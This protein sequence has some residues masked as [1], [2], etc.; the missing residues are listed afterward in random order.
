MKTIFV[1]LPT[2]ILLLFNS[3]SGLPEGT[4]ALQGGGS[5]ST[6]GKEM[7]I[8]APNGSI[9]KHDR[10][11]LDSDETVRFNQ[12]STQARV[13]NRITDSSP[14]QIN[15][16][17]QA[18]GQVYLVN[19]AGV[20]FGEDSSVE[21][22]RLHVVAGQ[23]SDEDF[24]ARRD[25]FSNLSGLIANQGQ[26]QADSVSLSGGTVHN[27][28]QILAPDGYIALSAGTSVE[29]SELDGSL[30]VS[31]EKGYGNPSVR[32]SSVM[33]D[34]AGQA[35]FG[36]G[37]LKASQVNLSASAI[38]PDGQIKADHVVLAPYSYLNQS[39][40]ESSIHTPSLEIQ[41]T[42]T[43]LEVEL[44]SPQ[45]EI[46][47]L[48]AQGTFQKLGVSSRSTL[49]VETLP[50]SSQDLPS[51]IQARHLDLRS[52]EGD[53][54]IKDVI[55]PPQGATDSTLLV[56]A[57]GKVSLGK[58]SSDYSYLRR[59][60]YGQLLEETPEITYPDDPSPSTPIPS[61]SAFQILAANEV[62][63]YDLS[64]SL[65]PELVLALAKENPVFAALQSTSDLDLEGLSDTQLKVLLEYGYLS[66]YSYFLKINPPR[67]IPL[68][69]ADVFGGDF[70]AVAKS[71]STEEDSAEESEDSGES[72]TADRAGTVGRVASA[73]P[74]API[75]TPVLSPAA[76][77]LLDDALNDQSEATLQRYLYK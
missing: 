26:I 39:T 74:F 47:N 71:E 27:Q 45:N 48:R 18:N 7:I 24:T 67:P 19:P 63:M 15:G 25:R 65:P 38:H 22:A 12:P 44:G 72:Q 60:A 17:I 73:I 59:V 42:S 57:R 1:L 51:S 5:F 58:P 2:F 8:T 32:N 34:I 46:S 77:R 28:G 6:S 68:S 10:F 53:L 11:N 4:E 43:G 66:G 70:S 21:A 36:S 56:A 50:P 55:S 40:I 29:L 61:E 41:S 76:S 52:Y 49:S 20:I 30:A 3:L 75:T 23:L 62:E 54:L 31:L 13:L 14:S 16:K 33:G 64:A 35:L 9:F 69:G 37:I